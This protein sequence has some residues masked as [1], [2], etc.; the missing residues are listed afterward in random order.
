MLCE[1]FN[2]APCVQ[3]DVEPLEKEIKQLKAQIAGLTIALKDAVDIIQAD[4]NT[5]EN[6]ASL[7]RMNNALQEQKS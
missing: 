2:V 3:C 5:E 6:S 1:H 7:C 4:A